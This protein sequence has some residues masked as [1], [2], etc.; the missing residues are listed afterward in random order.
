MKFKCTF[1]NLENGS[2]GILFQF[3]AGEEILVGGGVGGN[4]ISLNGSEA[5]KGVQG[6]LYLGCSDCKVI[7]TDRREALVACP[8]VVFLYSMI[9]H[10][11]LLH[12]V[13]GQ[14]LMGFRCHES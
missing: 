2:P 12:K 11:A 5:T 1:A 9:L 7:K 4:A 6:G 13:G 14:S 3:Q 8:M 10:T